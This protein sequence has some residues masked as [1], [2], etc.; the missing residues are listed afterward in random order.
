M[1]DNAWL[2]RRN[3]SVHITI[4]DIDCEGFD[5]ER[6][7]GDMHALHVTFFSFFAGG[8]V[9]TYPTRLA[10]QRMSP[11]LA[12]RDL[13]GEIID[14]AHRKD[15]K[16]IPMI[17]LGQ[18][19]AHAADDHPEWCA[20]D[21]DG[22]PYVAAENH[23]RSCTMGGY[24]AEY[25]REMVREIVERYPV[26][27]MKFGGA[28]YGFMG[29]ICYCENC[30][31]SFYEEY[32]YEI[33]RTRD[34]TDP[35]WKKFIRWR[36]DKVVLRVESLVNMVHEFRAG[37]PVMGNSVCF[38]NPGWTMRASYD[39]ERVATVQDAVQV[40]AQTR[41]E[42]AG[43][44]APVRW[45][46]LRW[47]A[48]EASYMTSVSDRPLWVVASYFCAWP[49]RRTAV[50]F[51]EQ[52]VYMAQIVAH[53]ASPMVNLSGGPPSVHEDTRGF[54]AMKEVYGFMERNDG[55]IDGDRSAATV[56]IV[57]SLET[58]V[59]YGQDDPMGRY[60]EEIRGVEQ[61][62]FEAHIPFDIIS[63]RTLDEETVGKYSVLIVPNG[64]CLSVKEAES[65]RQ[66]AS[67]GGGVVAT[68]ETSL[69]THTGEKREE[70]LLHDLWGAHYTG[71]TVL[72]AGNDSG[73][74]SQAYLRFTEPSA[75][76]EHLEE[77][78]LVLIAGSCCTVEP[79]NSAAVAMTLEP[80]FRVFPEGLSYPEGE[81]ESFPAAC[82]SESESGGR[83]VYFPVQIG[84]TF[85]TTRFPDLAVLLR[86]AV[87]WVMKQPLP[88]KVD[89]PSTLHTALRQKD[90]YTIVH[91]INLTGGE[92]FFT[93]LIPV[94]DVRIGIP[95]QDGKK[96]GAMAV[97]REEPLAVAA[98]EGYWQV[99]VPQI[100]DYEIVVFEH[101]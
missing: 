25:S 90:N 47:P 51:H 4:R 58:L 23:F 19:P 73:V 34:W 93:E 101:C 75:L 43:T 2:Y 50:P 67:R 87:R 79:E 52:K 74:Y 76:R 36:M 62:L 37:L 17:D 69:Y 42:I 35:V 13:A 95:I 46:Y 86:N 21:R 5:V 24:V 80:A 53:G 96:P 40:E 56:A 32:G 89:A 15:I 97:S 99:T 84:K 91:C 59:Y 1:M 98:H 14:E 72:V 83:T 20:I 45:Q 100:D 81:G 16:A 28:S 39:M 26:D 77:T 27:G 82:C 48:E 12:G 3:R 30:R 49:W 9:T 78:G 94:H 85:F 66:F 38:G 60:V 8:Y 61:A 6:F 63:T 92:R 71:K 68:F 70:A 64:A 54:R 55:Y 65:V 31:R 44:D 7:I 57:Y 29:N 18:L 10:Y 22:K 33:P 41:M 88:L 11:W